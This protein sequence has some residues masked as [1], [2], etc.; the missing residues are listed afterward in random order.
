MLLRCVPFVL[1]ALAVT[2]V[3]G[4]APLPRTA[5]WDL[6]ALASDEVRVVIEPVVMGRFA[7]SLTMSRWGDNRQYIE[8]QRTQEEGMRQATVGG[9]L[10]SSPGRTELAFD[11][12]MRTY[13]A[14]L[15]SDAEE[16]RLR[17][18][19][20]VGLGLHR[21]TLVEGIGACRDVCPVTGVTRAH[22]L[23]PMAELG[24]RFEP[25]RRVLLDVGLRT[26]LVTFADPTGRFAPGDLL[27]HL[28]L[29]LGMGW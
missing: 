17:A 5:S 6:G 21:R 16:H 22:G 8:L 23:E 2:S 10:E 1:T 9:F 28:T 25:A 29:A 13:P 26:R 27:P 24:V 4:Q 18:F 20:G 14:L 12:A 19:A 3:G 11:L 15:A 7:L